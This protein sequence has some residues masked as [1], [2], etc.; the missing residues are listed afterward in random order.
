MFYI[1][2]D[3]ER[4]NLFKIPSTLKSRSFSFSR[5]ILP[6]LQFTPL[7]LLLDDLAVEKSVTR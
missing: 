7:Q 4:S 3:S 5:P 1:F 6:M 2:E